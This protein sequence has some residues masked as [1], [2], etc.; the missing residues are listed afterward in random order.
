M[1]NDL[2]LY[3]INGQKIRIL[4]IVVMLCW[5]Y[6]FWCQ[7]SSASVQDWRPTDRFQRSWHERS[8]GAVW[9]F[10]G[11]GQLAAERPDTGQHWNVLL[12]TKL[13]D[14][15]QGQL[16][17]VASWQNSGAYTINSIQLQYLHKFYT[18]INQTKLPNNRGSEMHVQ[19]PL[20]NVHGSY[21][22]SHNASLVL[23]Q[24]LQNQSQL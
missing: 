7:E 14:T 8:F 13:L 11:A 22:N 3:L 5:M 21:N 9:F 4:G 24:S 17:C 23:W 18:K 6:L 12:F 1:N 19:A 15:T 2:N 16:H 20:D 10:N